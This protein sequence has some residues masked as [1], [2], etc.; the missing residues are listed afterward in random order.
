MIDRALAGVAE[1]LEELERVGHAPGRES[2]HDDLAIVGRLLGGA[3]RLQQAQASVVL[4]D[5]LDRVGPL[6]LQPGLGLDRALPRAPECR[7]HR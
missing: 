3:E 5:R 2:L 6:E 1:P 7:H 4:G